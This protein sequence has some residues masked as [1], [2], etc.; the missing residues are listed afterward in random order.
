[1][2]LLFF[3]SSRFWLNVEQTSAAGAAEA[4]RR[5]P[6]QISPNAHVR[7]T[8]EGRQ[9]PD[10]CGLGHSGQLPGKLWRNAGSW[11]GESHRI[12]PAV[13]TLLHL[14]AFWGFCPAELLQMRSEFACCEM[15]LFAMFLH[16]CPFNI[17]VTLIKGH[18]CN[19]LT[20][21][22]TTMHFQWAD[23]PQNNSLLPEHLSSCGVNE[24]NRQKQ[25]KNQISICNFYYYHRRWKSFHFHE[26]VQML[27]VTLAS[28]T[29][30]S[31]SHTSDMF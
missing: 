5:P 7:L 17:F 27:T 11:T 14:V 3:I 20:V 15:E 21:V 28:E 24:S 19:Q 2:C 6:C 9:G 13:Y 25:E 29:A 16:R 18:G 8:A 23:S 12:V 26:R 1:M 10:H 4:G 30:G 22:I 31:V